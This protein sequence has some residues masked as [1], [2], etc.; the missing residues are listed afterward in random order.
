[1]TTPARIASS[2]STLAFAAAAA[3]LLWWLYQGLQHAP[4]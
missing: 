3:A 2:V 4:F 1:M